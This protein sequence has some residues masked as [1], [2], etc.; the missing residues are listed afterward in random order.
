MAMKLLGKK[1]RP[2]DVK[3][4]GMIETR[5]AIGTGWTR[6]FELIFGNLEESKFLWTNITNAA[7]AFL[8][9]IANGRNIML[10][11]WK[12]NG[13]EA[14]INGLRNVGIALLYY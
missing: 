5:A 7:S 12:D 1:A 8:D 10:E 11:F 3:S 14:F 9:T 4:F 2:Q 6:T 13:G